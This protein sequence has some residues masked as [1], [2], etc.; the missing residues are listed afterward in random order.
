MFLLFS[1]FF[2]L[3]KFTFWTRTCPMIR[4]PANKA[5][6]SLLLFKC[7]CLL[8]IRGIML[9]VLLL[10]L[11]DA[12]EF[13]FCIILALEVSI[14]FPRVSFALVLSST[15]REPISST[16]LNSCLLCVRVV[17]K[18]VQKGSNLV[19]I[20]PTTNLSDKMSHPGFR[21]PKLGREHNHQVCWDQVSHI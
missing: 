19:I 9:L 12:L 17:V 14:L 20:P 21:G 16:K 6:G 11:C 8:G 3:V 5:T 15:S 13:F 2:L 10:L 1:W 18:S 4:T 7:G